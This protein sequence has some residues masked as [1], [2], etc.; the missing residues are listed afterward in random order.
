[1]AIAVSKTVTADYIAQKYFDGN[2]KYDARRGMAFALFALLYQSGLQY[3]FHVFCF[4]R[5]F[6][7]IRTWSTLSFKEK[8]FS[9]PHGW[10]SVVGQNIIDQCGITWIYYPLFYAL[11]G[12]TQSDRGSIKPA[13]LY[14]AVKNKLRSNFIDDVTTSWVVWM[15]ANMLVFALPLWLRLPVL[16]SIS[17]GWI[18][19][20]SILRGKEKSGGDSISEVNKTD[21]C[22]KCTCK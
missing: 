13:E 7:T 3:F 5:M 14:T 16:H 20:L 9:Q 12:I 6:P 17:F 21:K 8:I 1:M 11:K 15:P 4:S 18:C 10:W 22:M 19:L 2:E